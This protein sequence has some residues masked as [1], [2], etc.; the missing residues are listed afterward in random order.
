MPAAQHLNGF[1]P[2]SSSILVTH[3]V[4]GNG[5]PDFDRDN[6]DQL[7]AEALG[8]DEHG[9]PNLGADVEVNHKLIHIVFQVG[10]ERALE[11][12]PFRAAPAAGRGNS[13]LRT[14]LE[15][16]QLAILRSPQ[17][18]FVKTDRQ[19]IGAGIKACPLYSWLVPT[20]L[21]LVASTDAEEV[22]EAVL[23]LFGSMVL[24]NRK[25]A[26]VSSADIVL[27]LLRNSITSKSSHGPS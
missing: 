14:C 20:L 26:S 8:F 13:Q 18:L 6:F 1:E 27:G 17:V 4:H 2:P 7:L 16:L 21:P 19:G 11:E 9:Q 12:D 5:V 22:R 24:A 10:I 23:E 25:C 15:V 3:V